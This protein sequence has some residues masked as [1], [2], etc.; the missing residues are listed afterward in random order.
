MKKFKLRNL[1]PLAGIACLLGVGFL[2]GCSGNENEQ[3]G[4]SRMMGSGNQ[5]QPDA[6]TAQGAKMQYDQEQRLKQQQADQP[7]S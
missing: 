5:D 7:A 4:I 2:T 3:E 6:D 1:P